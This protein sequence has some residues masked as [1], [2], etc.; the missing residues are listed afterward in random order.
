MTTNTS[1]IDECTRC[2]RQGHR[3]SDCKEEIIYRVNYEKPVQ[4]IE[5][6]KVKIRKSKPA[7]T[8]IIKFYRQKLKRNEG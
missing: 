7:R 4:K 1:L 2:F 6:F 5:K 8:L 3:N